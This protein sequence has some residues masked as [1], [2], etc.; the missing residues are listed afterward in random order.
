TTF[1]YE[2]ESCYNLLL[3]ACKEL[4]HGARLSVQFPEDADWLAAEELSFRLQSDPRF[5]G[6]GLQ[7]T[8]HC[9]Q[10]ATPFDQEE[11]GTVVI[12]RTE[13]DAQW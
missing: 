13:P 6:A 1:I 9:V 5:K 7:A 4:N 8:A 11:P 12:K 3:Q 10:Y 2:T